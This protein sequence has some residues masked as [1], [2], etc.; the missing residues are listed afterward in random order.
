MNESDVLVVEDE[1]DMADAMRR[2]L[3]YAG[4]T[5][6]VA[7][8]GKKALEAV[9]ERMPAVVLLDILMPVMDGWECARRLRAT[10]GTQLP[11]VVV[12]AAEH[13][14]ARCVEVGA[15]HLLPK[16]FDVRELLRLVSQYIPSGESV[17]RRG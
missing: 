4:F 2:L 14:E 10:Y 11:I 13:V 7:P 9:A 17:K 16:P 12:T 3:E 1:P 6:R 5:A 8:N 15:D